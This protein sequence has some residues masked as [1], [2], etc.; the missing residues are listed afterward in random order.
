MIYEAT[1]KV[2][3]KEY[4]EFTKQYKMI[5]LKPIYKAKCGDLEKNWIMAHKRLIIS[6]TIPAAHIYD[7]YYRDFE[8]KMIVSKAKFYA[9]CRELLDLKM[10][11]IRIEN[12][13]FNCFVKR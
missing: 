4:R 11:V 5:K 7:M 3:I 13:T 2:N 8:E 9:E 12:N 6:A 10:Q 1:A